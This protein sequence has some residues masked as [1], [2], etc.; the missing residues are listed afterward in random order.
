MP[1]PK[2]S[3][4]TLAELRRQNVSLWEAK[5]YAFGR[6]AKA[7]D[8][9]QVVLKIPELPARS[10]FGVGADVEAAIADALRSSDLQIRAGGL[11]G[12]MALLEDE[13]RKTGSAMLWNGGGRECRDRGEDLDDW[14]PF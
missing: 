1:V 14:V 6:T 12:A 11:L 7:S 9:V 13:L 2:V 4:A 5:N 8:P 10:F 3:A